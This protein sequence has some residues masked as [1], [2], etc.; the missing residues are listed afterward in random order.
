MWK[1]RAC[2]FFRLCLHFFFIVDRSES[3]WLVCINGLTL[4]SIFLNRE[5]KPS[6]GYWSPNLIE[7]HPHTSFSTSTY[8][9]NFQDQ[10]LVV[11]LP[12]RGSVPRRPSHRSLPALCFTPSSRACEVPRPFP[13]ETEYEEEGGGGVER[14]R[15]PSC[16]FTTLQ[17]I[18]VLPVCLTLRQGFGSGQGPHPL[19]ILIWNP[20]P[21][22]SA[23]W[24]PNWAVG[25]IDV[26]LCFQVVHWVRNRTS[27]LILTER[28][29]HSKLEGRV[30]FQTSC[31]QHFIHYV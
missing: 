9:T 15:P 23:R 5:T 20:T 22:L 11:A 6:A 30:H 19:Y 24:A 16:I 26:P 3:N 18:P 29:F 21:Q 7:L 1:F 31:F 17:K 4:P 27:N 14:G 2:F 12:N 13:S 25:P 8:S 10:P 28:G